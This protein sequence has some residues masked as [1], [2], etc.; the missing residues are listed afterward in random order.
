M[1]KLIGIFCLALALFMTSCA[2]TM[3]TRSVSQEYTDKLETKKTMDAITYV[4][5]NNGFD[6]K[7]INDTYGLITTEWR[8][9][10]NSLQNIGLT[11]LTASKY[12]STTYTDSLQLTFNVKETGY[13][14]VPK[15]M[16]TSSTSNTWSNT[17]S[18][19]AATYP[20]ADS[21]G[22]KL[23]TKVMKEINELIGIESDIKWEEKQIT[24]E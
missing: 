16:R 19:S 7:T 4:L 5:S 1:K 20:T 6:V 15:T 21:I 12:F 24:V 14:V 22:G 17:S 10:D 3:I 2:T 23:T 11:I 13:T 18:N 8:S 9:L